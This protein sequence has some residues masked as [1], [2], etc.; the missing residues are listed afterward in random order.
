MKSLKLRMLLLL[1]VIGLPFLVLA[2]FT[3]KLYRRIGSK[4]L[5]ISTKA[6]RKIGVFPIRNHY[7]EPLFDDEILENDLSEPRLLPGIDFNEA[8][9][10]EFLTNLH[11]QC[12][13]DEFIEDEE[14]NA[15]A[16][17]FRI[18]NG[19]FESGDAEFLFNFVRY[20]KPRKIIEIGCGAST[21]IIHKAIELNEEEGK[22]ADHI[23][24]EPYE[25]PWLEKFPKIELVRDRVESISLELFQ[26]LNAGDFLFIDSSHMIRPQ[27]D[28]LHEYLTIIPSLREG[29]FVHVH[30]IFS[31]RDYLNDWIINKVL[32][33]NEQYLLEA[34]LT[35]STSFEVVAALNLLKTKHY[36]KLL[37]VC[38]YL[39]EGREPGSLYFRT[40]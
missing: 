8:G 18:D 39:T 3:L 36:S 4:R 14:N 9:Q 27:G 7:Y 34:L 15:D 17:A 20:T 21:K 23:C 40:H 24:V 10:I 11:Y 35:R 31:P 5:K 1:E 38:P 37:K 19:T 33:W 2:A 28:V 26:D 6:L 32:F 25:R 13:F 30:D 29:V 22:V 16:S 12:E